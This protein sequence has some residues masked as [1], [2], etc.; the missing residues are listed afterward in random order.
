VDRVGSIIRGGLLWGI[1]LTLLPGLLGGY[2]LAQGPLRRVRSIEAAIEPVMRG[3]LGA[4][5]PVSS[6]H[7]E[8]DML[9]A[10]VNRMLE[11][12]ERLLGEVKG[13]SDSI[14][15]DLRTPLTRLRA[16]LH[17][18]Q[19]DM[20]AGENAQT[21]LERCVA[22]T[23]GLLERFRALLRISELEDLHRRAGFAEVDLND[24]LR[25]AHEL[26]APL[27]EDKSLSF[28]LRTREIPR[29]HADGDLL[30]EAITNL[31]SNAIKFT[32]AGGG[33]VLS[34]ALEPRGAVIEVA[35][36]GPG[37]APDERHAVMQRFYRV[38]RGEHQAGY[39]LGLSIVAAI[40]RLHGFSL[41]I[42]SNTPSGARMTL[43]CFADP[44]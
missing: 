20:P 16:Q 30:F 21:I 42:G 19:R 23:D 10:T 15:H 37:I 38:Q 43:R 4:R 41:A 2:L 8:L 27:A 34:S 31:I 7:D 25:R 14:A 12:I 11:Q 33:I 35:D 17:R 18:L 6:R 1:S 40:V 24:I 22:D 28:T 13:V 29:V 39:G 32:P 26:Y 9:S 36:S 5:L 3:N 44:S